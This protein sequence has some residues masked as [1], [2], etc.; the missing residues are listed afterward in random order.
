[1]HKWWVFPKPVTKTNK[2]N[3]YIA[4][5]IFNSHVHSLIFMKLAS[6]IHASFVYIVPP[7]TGGT[8]QE[9]SATSS[10]A[11]AS[12]TQNESNILNM[13]VAKWCVYMEGKVWGKQFQGFSC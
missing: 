2:V 1:M 13:T 9:A 3:S 7:E 6:L 10:N 11:V 8:V 4:V 5:A 12:D